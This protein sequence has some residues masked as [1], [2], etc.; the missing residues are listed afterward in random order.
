V[1]KKEKKRKQKD[2]EAAPAATGTPVAGVEKKVSQVICGNRYE[3]LTV[4]EEE[5]VQGV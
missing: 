3:W 5:E 2:L 4:A 1:S